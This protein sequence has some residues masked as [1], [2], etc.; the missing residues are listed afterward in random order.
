MSAAQ[1]RVRL[2]VVDTINCNLAVND[3]EDYIEAHEFCN[4]NM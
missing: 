1:N 2:S 4:N 3:M